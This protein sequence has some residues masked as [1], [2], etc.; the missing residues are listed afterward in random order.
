[1][2]G[3]GAHEKADCLISMKTHTP[4]TLLVGAEWMHGCV[5]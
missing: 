4:D 2:G 5:D 3:V 1:M